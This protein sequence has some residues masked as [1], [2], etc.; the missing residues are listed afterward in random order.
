VTID[1]SERS[2]IDR[3]DRSDRR[4]VLIVRIVRVVHGRSNGPNE[5]EQN[6]YALQGKPR[7]RAQLLGANAHGFLTI[8]DLY[9][10]NP[11]GLS[12]AR[13]TASQLVI[14]IVTAA[15]RPME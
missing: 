9:N 5:N 11:A 4:V 3:S 2:T 14:F 7:L 12:L 6:G 8:I 10:L 1:R 15:S 13:L